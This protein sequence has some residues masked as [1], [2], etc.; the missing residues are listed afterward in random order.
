MLNKRLIAVILI[1]DDKIIQSENFKHTNVIHNSSEIAVDTFSQWRVDEI[2]ILNVSKNKNEKKFLKN[3]NK[4]LKKC[5]IPITVGGWIDNLNFAKQIFN[6]GAD[7]ISINSA[8]VKDFN[9]VRRLSDTYGAQAL[10]GSID[11]KILNKKKIVYIDRGR[12]STNIDPLYLAKKYDEIIGEILLTSIDNEGNANGYD[13][14]TLKEVSDQIKIPVI[15][16]GGAF[17]NFQFYDGFMNGA[18][19]VAAANYFH[20][21]EF[22]TYLVK[23]YLKLKNIKLREY[24]D[25]VL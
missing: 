16:F 1:D 4:I 13:L 2:I 18:S 15:A 6:E 19:A 14:I 20:Y 24:D 5:F 17:E 9:F 3:L 22:S 10:V 12:H 8:L 23:N 25:Y 11:Y 7:K 21:K